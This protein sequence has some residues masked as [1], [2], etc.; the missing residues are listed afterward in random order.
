MAQVS[1]DDCCVVSISQSMF[2]PVLLRF[3]QPHYTTF[4]ALGS[5][6]LWGRMWTNVSSYCFRDIKIKFTIVGKNICDCSASYSSSWYRLVQFWRIVDFTTVSWFLDFVFGNKLSMST[7][8][9]L[10]DIMPTIGNNYVF[11][12]TPRVL[13]SQQQSV[14]VV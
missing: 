2:W 11:A 4:G 13:S 8:I 5:E 1:E 7:I 12:A 3:Y 9:Y 10:D 6:K 14:A